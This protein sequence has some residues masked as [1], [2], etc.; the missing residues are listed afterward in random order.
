VVT[1]WGSRTL[2]ESAEGSAR[3]E[4]RGRRRRLA[5][6]A[7]AAAA[8]V[9]GSS[10]SSGSAHP[11]VTST[12]TATTARPGASSVARFHRTAV[13]WE[14]ATFSH[15]RLDAR[16]RV[17]LIAQGHSYL[18]MH[19]YRAA[20]PSILALLY[21]EAIYSDSANRRGGRSRANP[22]AVGYAPADTQH[23]D[24]FLLDSAGQR[25][26]RRG[27]PTYV[28]MDIGNAGYQQAWARNAIRAARRDGW[29]GVF[30]DDL[31]L[32]LPDVSARPARYPDDA[33]WRAAVLS[34]VQAVGTQLHAAHLL[35][36]TNTASGVTYPLA[37]R[38]LLTWV[39]G[40][41]EE[42]WM[43][44]TTEHGQPLATLDGAWPRQLDELTAAEARGKYFL[45][46]LPADAS[47]VQAIRYGLAT[48]LL[49]AS[50]LSSYDVSGS[51][52][53]TAPVWLEPDYTDARRLGAP[54]GTYWVLASGVFRRDFARGSVLVNPWTRARTVRL[55]SAYSGSGLHGVREVEMP[56]TTGLVLLRAS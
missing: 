3:Q 22:G 56:A 49:G 39:D 8:A 27:T 51:P 41:M 11:P 4:S 43:R 50:G 31:S 35:L 40:T 25:I 19:R 38:A 21:K 47:D 46:E 5:G 6:L 17:L 20:N 15:V 42:G 16:R 18:G 48:Y 34:F 30:A 45:A 24:W 1:R 52:P 9:L 10:C 44:P 33:A 7:V 36:F 26:H 55:G 14:G 54:H 53:Y 28:L 29:D 37:W 2:L 23:P 13:D 12:P 32:S